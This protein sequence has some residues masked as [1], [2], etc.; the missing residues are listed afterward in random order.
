[1]ALKA[2]ENCSKSFNGEEKQIFCSS[3]CKQQAYRKRKNEIQED[4]FEMKF[5]LKEFERLIQTKT[6][7]QLKNRFILY[8]FMRK[9]LP[10]AI[11]FESLILYFENN[12]EEF[13]FV[14]DY[15]ERGK[16]LNSYDTFYE[17]Y[18]AGEIEVVEEYNKPGAFAGGVTTD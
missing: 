10:Q 14:T 7:E 9:N 15:P 4:L 16:H 18:M 2:C 12:I 1:M 6:G 17:K 3:T 5:S 11:S 8:C 13:L